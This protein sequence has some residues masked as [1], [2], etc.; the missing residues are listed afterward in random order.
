MGFGF[1]PWLLMLSLPSGPNGVDIHALSNVDNELDVGVV[2][3]VG[4][5]G[6]LDIVVG[7]ANVVG[8]G[9]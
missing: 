4:A 3:V 9:L 7:H 8:V 1:L 5:A 2:V 6:N